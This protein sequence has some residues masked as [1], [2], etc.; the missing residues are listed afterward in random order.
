M[1]DKCWFPLNLPP[2]PQIE[3]FEVAKRLNLTPYELAKATWAEVAD[4][5]V[6]P[7]LHE[8]ISLLK[9][10]YPFKRAAV[11]Y[12]MPGRTHPIHVDFVT[13]DVGRV[14]TSINVVLFGKGTHVW[15]ET[16]QEPSFGVYND[17]AMTNPINYT[18]YN[19]EHCTKI[20]SWDGSGWTILKPSIPHEIFPDGQRIVLVFRNFELSWQ[21]GLELLRELTLPRN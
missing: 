18:E 10:Y 20:D 1:N 16:T 21:Q 9:R 8:A 7:E 17:G 3:P 6:F 13:H 4:V 12:T 14:A 11:A 2:I 15:Y 19:R 5:S